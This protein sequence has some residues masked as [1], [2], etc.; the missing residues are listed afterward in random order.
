MSI[1][2]GEYTYNN[3]NSQNLG[4][5]SGKRLINLTFYIC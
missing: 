3:K 2:K 4:N 5:K 1:N